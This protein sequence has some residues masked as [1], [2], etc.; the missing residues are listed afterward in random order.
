MGI[1]QL[2]NTK[3]FLAVG[4]RVALG[5]FCVGFISLS[6]SAQMRF[7]PPTSEVV[8]PISVH[9]GG[10]K[11]NAIRALEK[12]WRGQPTDQNT[13]LAY[14][15][16]VFTLGLSEGDLRWFGSAKAALTP[17]WQSTS[18]PA[19]GFFLR[20]LVKQGFHD[21]NSGLSD[22]NRAIELEPQRAE[23]WSW[24]FA[25]HLLMADMVAVQ[26]DVDQIE[27]LIGHEEAN[28]YRGIV[29]YRSGQASAAVKVL[30]RAK[31]SA[32][33]QDGSSQDWLG[34]HLG[35][36]Y[37][38]NG[39]SSQAMTLWAEC[40]KLRPQSHLIRLSLAELYN[41]LGEYDKAK[42][43]AINQ[44]ASQNLTDALLMQ[45]LIASR[46]LRE[47]DESRLASQMDARLSAQTLRQESLIER[48]KLIYQITY[49]KD[50]KA[51]LALS[52]EN[53]QLQK[54]PPDAILFLQAA[55]ALGE[56]NAA[57]PV[58]KWVEQTGY[59][60]PQLNA[61]IKQLKAHTSWKK[62]PL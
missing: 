31:Q 14:A 48:P 7:L 21:F 46:G 55:I 8:L 27:R 37:R 15:R 49:G 57:L 23:F 2:I 12:A 51:G 34:F 11:Q 52:I 6:A 19:E 60:D 61:L 16:A 45:A 25:L 41:H 43:V 5:C 39:Q 1:L 24:R 54:E 42:K 4:R 35:E 13:A 53:W 47:A 56:A 18:L 29:L 32:A 10:A 20:G 28:I 44:V 17:W 9:S 26:H 22:I 50:I 62:S 36:A 33:Y 40:L 38:V 3:P 30:S 59:G 58:V